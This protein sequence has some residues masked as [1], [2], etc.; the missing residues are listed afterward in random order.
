MELYGLIGKKLEHSFSP[1]YFRNKFRELNLDA[2]YLLFELD[3]ISEFPGL[4]LKHKNLKG[5]N[6]TIPYKKEIIP[7]LDK[8][9]ETAISVGA[10]NTIKIGRSS[11][12][13]FLEGYNTDITGFKEALTPLLNKRN[14][15]HALILGTG[16]SANAVSF[17][18]ERMNI[19]FSFVS[20]NGK[21]PLLNYDELN[22]EIISRSL[23]IV[24][25][26][27]L[28]MFPRVNEFPDIPYEFLTKDH[29]IFD[30]IYNPAETVFL[31]KA[32]R[33]GALTS[34]GMKM[35]EFQAEASWK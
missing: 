23:L 19:D 4:I 35:L 18:L 10:V 3:N 2:R 22:K 6:V 28:G 8:P 25:T 5:L 1:G 15:R 14:V 24:N 33:K 34:N 9:D 21:Q 31:K 7:F 26:T 12:K 13:L 32:R 11:G 27:P 29:V 20:R 16:G 30:L 17:V